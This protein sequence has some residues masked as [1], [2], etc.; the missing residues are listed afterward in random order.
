MTTPNSMTHLQSRINRRI[1]MSE[2]LLERMGVTAEA[3]E[4]VTLNALVLNPALAD[5]TAES[6]DRAILQCIDAGLMPNGEEAAIVP[7]RK[8]ATLVPMIQGRLK[9][10]RRAMPGLSLRS[11]RVY[12]DDEFEY[13]DGLHPL[14]RHVPNPIGSHR[15]QDLRAV[16]AVARVP[17]SID[18][19]FVV[20]YQPDIDRYRA[21]SRA[22]T[23]PW[24]THYQQM[25]EN[26]A[27]K[28]LLKKLPK[29]AH[30]FRLPDELDDL[31][32]MTP[33][34]LHPEPAPVP[35]PAAPPVEYAIE[36]EPAEFDEGPF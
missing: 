13:S 9:L 24:E 8:E 1:T 12:V 7:F 23:G 11:Q 20:C 4:R 35:E 26:V 17:G 25:A 2:P 5:C 27:V 34:S 28:M 19:E 21:Y 3:F 18:P 16:Y 15:D 31:D 6:L 30:G 32:I 22:K 14:L 10:A 29:S 36:E 33:D